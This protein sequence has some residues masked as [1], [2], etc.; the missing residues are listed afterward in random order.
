MM[1]EEI[2]PLLLT[3][4]LIWFVSLGI[5]ILTAKRERKNKGKVVKIWKGILIVVLIC[6][7]PDITL[8]FALDSLI[9]A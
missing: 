8:T 3:L 9:T 5:A 6:I 4:I 1:I 7:A 2:Q